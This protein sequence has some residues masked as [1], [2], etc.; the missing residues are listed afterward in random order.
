MRILGIDLETT[1]LDVTTERPVEIGV[2]LWDVESKKPIVSRGFFCWEESYPPIQPDAFKTHG[3]TLEVIKE[4]GEHP[5]D[6]L[7]WIE[8]FIVKHGVTALC[9]HNG[10]GYDKPL[11]LNEIKRL[12]LDLPRLTTMH[13]ID[14]QTDLPE[15]GKSRSLLYMA[16][17]KGFVNPYSHRAQFDVAAM[18]K[19]LSHYD[20]AEVVRQGM[21]PKVKLRGRLSPGEVGFEEKKNWL[22]AR[23]YSWDGDNK[24]WVKEFKENEIEAERNEALQQGVKLVILV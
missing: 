17:E 10:N 23:R 2:C 7:Q 1:G 13:W 22:K 18:L 15:Y 24:Y 5:K 19:I 6:V 11:L 4:F 12:G 3:I 16:A 21:I 9:A 20:V 14:T 8:G